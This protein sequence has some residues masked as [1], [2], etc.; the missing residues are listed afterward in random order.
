MR[1]DYLNYQRATTQCLIGAAVQGVLGVAFL[2]YGIRAGDHAMLTAGVLI[3]LGLIVWISLAILFDQHRRER[4]EA[5]EQE[6]LTANQG[7]SVFEETQDFRVAAKRLAFVEKFFIPAVSILLGVLLVSF[8]LLRFFQGRSLLDP[9][10]FNAPTDRGWALSVS[11]GAAFVGFL[12]ARYIAAMAK[13]GIWAPLRAG[14][15]QAVLAS[16][17]GLCVAVGQFVDVYGTDAFLRYLQVVFP[18]AGVVLG[19]EVF[20]NFLLDLYR[21]RRAGEVRPAPFDSKLLSFVAAPDRI[22]QSVGEL[23]NYQLGYDVSSTWLYRLLSRSLGTLALSALLVMWALSALTVVQPHQRGLVL[24]FGVLTREIGPG[25][26]LKWPWPIEAVE[27]PS[28]GERDAK[29]VITDFG[30]T[31]TTVRTLELATPSVV[32]DRDTAV[33]WTHDYALGEVYYFV[34]PS[35]IDENPSAKDRD[36]AWLNDLSLIAVEAP[37]RYAIRDVEKFD[38]LGHPTQ[39]ENILRA[40]ARR[41]VV[42]VLK[43]YGIDD[44]LGPRRLEA[45]ALIHSSIQKAFDSLNLGADG[46]PVGA[47][48]EVLSVGLIGVHPHKS[49]APNFEKVVQAQQGAEGMIDSA[50]AQATRRL[51]SAAGDQTLARQLVEAIDAREDL[52]SGSPEAAQ[53]SERIRDLLSRCDGRVA[54]M[55]AEA[56]GQR[57]TKHMGERA[58]A[59]QYAGLIKSFESN[60]TL[61]RARMYMDALRDAMYNSRVVITDDTV[62]LMQVDVNLEDKDMGTDIFQAPPSE[63]SN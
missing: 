17:V 29:G 54:T 59:M 49:V 58:R 53:A 25:L 50:R 9:S 8:G 14:A 16:L 7:A 4:I 3:S 19:V 24:R 55:L 46:K 63:G 44:L 60:P 35:T 2:A 15:A 47:G 43:N 52:P 62:R 40:A 42:R 1:A 10:A 30:R 20:L 37:L 6:A 31:T 51:I 13:Q 36:S 11:I 38:L 33:L 23:V 61:F 45:Q 57:W 48:V 41:V 26:H 12:F 21:P 18:I 56:R 32:T 22:A 28:Y 27:I 5:I 39:R 34:R